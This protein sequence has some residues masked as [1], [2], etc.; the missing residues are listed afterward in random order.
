VAKQIQALIDV[1]ATD[2]WA[3]FFPVGDDQ[4]A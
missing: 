2:L 3:G 4:A 1:G